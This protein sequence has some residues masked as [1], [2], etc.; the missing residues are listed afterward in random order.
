MR[1]TTQKLLL[2][3]YQPSEQAPFRLALTQL[4]W[5]LPKLS[6]A[7]RRSL[8]Y[9]LVQKG[10][11]ESV[12][13]DDAVWLSL[14]KQ[15]RQLLEAKF[16]ALN[17]FWHDWSGEWSQLLFLRP[18]KGDKQFRYLRGL[19][20]KSGA[21]PLMRGVYLW[22]TGLSGELSQVCE[23][24][25]H[26]AVLLVELNKVVIGDLRPIVIK[27]YSL[28]ELYNAYSG[29]SRQIDLLLNKVKLQNEWLMKEKTQFNLILE[30]IILV[31]TDD[32]GLTN[33]Y[34]PEATRP[35]E[36]IKQMQLIIKENRL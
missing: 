32:L 36:L 12:T 14:T 7:G 17:S 11:I 8:I 30:K 29:I 6:A 19:A 3:L 15:G 18:P 34:F 33:F 2:L 25:Y 9:L 1:K 20:L 27:Y 35:I 4:D 24:F 28:T 31:L 13:L 16:R 10:L 23:R 22:P 21:L 5:L 26:Q